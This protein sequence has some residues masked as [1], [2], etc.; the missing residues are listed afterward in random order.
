[1][2]CVQ[3]CDGLYHFA[4]YLVKFGIPLDPTRS[5][6]LSRVHFG[7]S[8]IVRLYSEID[9]IHISSE[10]QGVSH[11]YPQVDCHISCKTIR[12]IFY[13]YYSINIIILLLRVIRLADIVPQKIHDQA[14]LHRARLCY[15]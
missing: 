6:P 13:Y 4:F 10:A 14:F 2:I 15:L 8:L 9:H 3:T 11:L 7:E 5:S 12:T 1:M